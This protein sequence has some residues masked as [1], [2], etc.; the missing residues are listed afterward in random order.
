M[1]HVACARLGLNRS[2]PPAGSPSALPVRTF[3][4]PPEHPM[5]FDV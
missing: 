4:R 1:F 2:D 5:L 3:R